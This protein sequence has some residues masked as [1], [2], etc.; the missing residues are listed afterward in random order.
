MATLPR[1]GDRILVLKEP[2]MRCILRGEK[3]MEVRGAR[4]KSGPVFFGCSGLVHASG[5]LGEAVP[6]TTDEAW[7]ELRGEHCV[8]TDVLPYKKTF[9]L[10]ILKVEKLVRPVRYRHPRGAVGIVKHRG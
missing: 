2:W 4:L 6:I 8:G 3:R 5:I 10:P 7:R 1:E 9:G